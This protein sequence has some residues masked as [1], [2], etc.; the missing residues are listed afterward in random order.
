MIPP[1]TNVIT[2][3]MFMTEIIHCKNLHA[4]LLLMTDALKSEIKRWF[5]RGT[6]EVIIRKHVQA[7]ENVLLQRI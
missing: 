1:N 3:K 4:S 6:L 2:P 5:E 7:D